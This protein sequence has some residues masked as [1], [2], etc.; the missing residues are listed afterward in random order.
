MRLEQKDKTHTNRLF[1]YGATIAVPH[2]VS[3]NETALSGSK[4]DSALKEKTLSLEPI[5]KSRQKENARHADSGYLAPRR[6][7]T[8]ETTMAFLPP[9]FE[10]RTSR[11]RFNRGVRKSET[12]AQR[13]AQ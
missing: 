1:A 13:K 12:K 6:T 10:K 3:Q 7:K 2:H 5:P 8:F 11:Q 9:S 4:W